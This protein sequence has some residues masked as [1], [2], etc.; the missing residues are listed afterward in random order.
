MKETAVSFGERGSLAGVLCEPEPQ[1]LRRG[2]PPVLLWNVGIQHHVGPYRIW[3]DLARQLATLGFRSLRFDLGNMGDSEVSRG[4][5][6]SDVAE[7]MTA[8][9]KR[10]GIH[11]FTLVGFCSSVDQLH[12]VG[13][14]D[15]RV[16]GMVYVEGYA[17]R[18]RRFWQRYPLRFLSTVR[19]QNKLQGRLE[20]TK[21]F[22]KRDGE[23]DA[24][25]LEGGAGAMFDRKY[26]EPEQLAR[27]LKAL[28]GRG[29]RLLLIYAGL[30]STFAHPD[31]LLDLTGGE[32]L[33]DRLKLVF[34]GGADHIFY[35]ADDRA[36]AVGEICRWMTE[37]FAG[38][39]T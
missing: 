1:A 34:M 14:V 4:S 37:S 17:Y 26:P 28:T 32:D 21:L 22:D 27:D 36:L 12:E 33:G 13:L 38:V 16:T 6:A 25:A 10:L 18:T 15:R 5:P 35:R 7:A 31:Q 23:L 8:L 39:A 24:V 20:W 19:W 11:E 3:V 9:E 2:A 30:D 29:V